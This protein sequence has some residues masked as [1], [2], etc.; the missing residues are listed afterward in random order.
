MLVKNDTNGEWGKPAFYTMGTASIG[1]EGATAVLSADMMT[2]AKTKGL[3]LGISLEDAVIAV[4]G[5]ESR[6]YYEKDIRPTDILLMRTVSSPQSA[7]LRA[8]LARAVEGE[9]PS[10]SDSFPSN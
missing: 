8:A 10:Q 7:G 1:V 2:S 5:E 4:R 6:D 3:F 9:T